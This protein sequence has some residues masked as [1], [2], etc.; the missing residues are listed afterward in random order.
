MRKALRLCSSGLFVILLFSGLFETNTGLNQKGNE[1]FKNKR[2]ESALDAYRKAQIRKPDQPETRYNLGTTLYQMDQ[3]QEAE[4]NLNQALQNAPTKELKARAWYNFGNTQYR[5]GQFDKAIEAYQKT[6]EL[7]P[8]DKD[9]KY[10]LE[11]LQKKKGL[12]E[13]KQNQRDREKKDK[14]PQQKNKNQQQQQQKREREQNQGG[15]SQEQ[16][17]SGR[18]GE[19]EQGQGQNDQKEKQEQEESGKGDK[20]EDQAP[21]SQGRQ[22]QE[23]ELKARREEGDQERDK[24]D[25]QDKKDKLGQELTPVDILPLDQQGPK[26]DENAPTPDKVLLQGQMSQQQAYR[27]L[28]ALKASEQQI[29]ILRRPSKPQKE[30]EPEK[31]W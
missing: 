3:F 24:Q 16:K 19:G 7:N 26:P 9:A 30:Q 5:L 25:Q 31:D 6:L 22:G 4:A 29:Q 10:N 21:E 17:E 13:N 12:F 1:H 18:Q 11:L 20:P 2:Y 14:P 15:G 23:Q 8:E 28:D 27:I